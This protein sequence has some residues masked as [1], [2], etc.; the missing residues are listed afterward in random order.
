MSAN[1][2]SANGGSDSVVASSHHQSGD[3]VVVRNNSDGGGGGTGGGQRHKGGVVLNVSSRGI[4]EDLGDPDSITITQRRRPGTVLVELPPKGSSKPAPFIRSMTTMSSVDSELLEKQELTASA[5][6]DCDGFISQIDKDGNIEQVPVKYDAETGEHKMATSPDSASAGDGTASEAPPT[7][8]MAD[9]IS[10]DILT[11]PFNF[12]SGNVRKTRFN[13]F[14]KKSGLLNVLAKQATRNRI[15]AKNGAMN[16]LSTVEGKTH[17]F[18]KDFFISVLDMSWHWL[19]LFFA[20]AFFSSWL[21]F[22]IVWYATFLQH[23]DFDEANLNNTDFVPCASA[24]QD[25]TSCFLFSV[26]TQH[27]IGYGGR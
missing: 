27:T 19:L 5:D 25:F 24:I 15:V 14:R 1:A 12:V 11:K 10:A 16:T 8:S 3:V 7:N 20:T 4:S 23:G 6:E 9:F 17:H 26:E 21:L 13:P 18:L 2:E 22:A